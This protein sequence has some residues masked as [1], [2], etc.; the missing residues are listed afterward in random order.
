MARIITISNHAT[1]RSNIVDKNKKDQLLMVLTTFGHL[2]ILEEQDDVYI[3]EIN[4]LDF[5]MIM[6]V[7]GSI[8]AF[9]NCSRVTDENNV[10]IEWQVII[11]DYA[12]I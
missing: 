12:R 7:L 10:F 6:N 2:N 8:G 5:T 3:I 4:E 9:F 1:G 11:Y